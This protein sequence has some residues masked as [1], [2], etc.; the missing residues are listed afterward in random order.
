MTLKKR[1]EGYMRDF[2]GGREKVDNAMD[3]IKIPP[4]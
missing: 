2:G 1:K 4:K 3:C